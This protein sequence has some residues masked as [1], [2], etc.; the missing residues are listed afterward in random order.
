MRNILLVFAVAMPIFVYGQSIES[1][2]QE[3]EALRDFNQSLN[4]RLDVLQ[5]TIDDVLWFNRLEDIAHVDKVYMYGPP[6]ANIPN[7]TAKGAN[8]PVKFWSYVFVPKNIDYS[9]KYPLLVLPHGGVHGDF[10]TYY[11]HIVR[12]LMAQGYIVVA[13]EYRGSTGYGKALWEQIDYGGLEIQDTYA[14]RNYM[15]EH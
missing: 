1:L 14:S 7:P 2:Q 13:P 15:I 9:K 12:E 11:Y 10:T 5:K 6:P 3:V 8:N 4:H